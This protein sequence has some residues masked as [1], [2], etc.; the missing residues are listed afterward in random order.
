M[1][2]AVASS[3]REQLAISLDVDDLV[4]ARR[5]AK[6]LQP[7]FGVA[8]VGLELFTAV[9]PDIVGII[10]DHGMKVFLDIKLHDNP[11]IVDRAARVMGSI[12]V[13]YLTLHAFG[14]AP[15]LRAGV[16]GLREGAA[17]AGLEAPKAIAIT[18]LTG[19]SEAPPYILGNRVRT[20]V[21]GGCDG[22]VCSP[23]DIREAKQLAPRLQ[24]VVTGVRPNGSPEDDFEVASTPES[25]TSA[26]ADLLVLGRAI[27][28][29]SDRLAAAEQLVAS[30][31]SES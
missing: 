21:E 28:G 24:A 2:T 31:S 29:A 13:S 27:T 5:L 20:A 16:D 18:I 26:G 8:K 6:E 23:Q 15:M 14:G 19:D 12:G 17:R 25:A 22:I 3:V 9:G 30:I 7:Y 11:A 1:T 4:E 10:A